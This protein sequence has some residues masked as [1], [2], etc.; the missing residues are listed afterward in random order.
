MSIYSLQMFTSSSAVLFLSHVMQVSSLKEL[1][2]DSQGEIHNHDNTPP[3]P[4]HP[5]NHKHTRGGHFDP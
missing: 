1:S 5:D 3:H 2:Y 4:N